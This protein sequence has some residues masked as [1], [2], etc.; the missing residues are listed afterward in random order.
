MS[1]TL[2]SSSA[3]FASNLSMLGTNICFTGKIGKDQFGRQILNSLSEK[4]IDTGHI[5]FSSTSKTGI[6]VALSY[7]NENAM[8]T[9]PGA[10][11]ELTESEISDKLLHSCKHLHVS[12]IFLQ[13]ALKKGVIPLFKR[14]KNAGLTT[15]LDTQWDPEENWDIDW[16]RLLPFVDVFLPNINEIKGITRQNHYEDCINSIKDFLNTIVIKNGIKGS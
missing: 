13:P 1:L 7:D 2:G 8:V 6:T 10:M 16:K 11:A 3:I 14:A 9:H 12:S 15:S 4:G 5:L